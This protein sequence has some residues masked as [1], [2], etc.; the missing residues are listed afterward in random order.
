MRLAPLLAAGAL[1][2]HKLA[3]VTNGEVVTDH[4]HSYLPLV[5]AVVTVLLALSCMRYGHE[6]W[7]ASRGRL[8]RASSPS[9][10]GL[11]LIASAALLSTFALQEWIEA[12]VTPGHPA[13][14]SHAVAHVGYLVPVLA[15]AMGAVIAL[16]LRASNTAIVLLA[17]RHLARRAPRAHRGRW[18]FVSPPRAPR[19]PV[20]AGNL[21]G[22]APPAASFS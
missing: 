16:V 4:G 7:H 21:A 20:L 6:L 19:L 2:L 9:L 8:S 10:R 3:G 15:V 11:W 17:R 14:L 12:W 5:A 22:R 1:L 18:A 13:A